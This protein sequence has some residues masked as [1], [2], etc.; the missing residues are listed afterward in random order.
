MP[1]GVHQWVVLCAYQLLAVCIC[2]MENVALLKQKKSIYVCVCVSIL[3][4]SKLRN[5]KANS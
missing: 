4:V 5:L 1:Q 3:L 2:A